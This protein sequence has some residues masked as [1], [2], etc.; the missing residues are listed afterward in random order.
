VLASE[1][2]GTHVSAA[3]VH[4]VQRRILRGF[5]IRE[6]LDA[7]DPAEAILGSV[8]RCARRLGVSAYVV[9]VVQQPGGIESDAR[10]LGA[11]RLAG[12]EAAPF[13]SALN[14]DPSAIPEAGLA[15]SWP[16]E[17]GRQ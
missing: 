8:I 17:V 1:V 16:D 3:L 14:P 7:N 5:R 9:T 12:S 13:S 11:K 2:G 15:L 4:P 10:W 6:P